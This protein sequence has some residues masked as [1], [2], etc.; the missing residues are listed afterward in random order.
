MDVTD[1]KGPSPPRLRVHAPNSQKLKLFELLDASGRLGVHRVHEV[2]AHF[3]SGLFAVVKDLSKDRLILDSRGANL[4]ERPAQRWIKTLATG[5]ALVKLLLA[6]KEIARSS[7]NDLRD[8]YYLFKVSERRSARNYLSGVIPAARIAHLRAMQQKG[9]SDGKVVASLRTLAMGDTWAV[10]LAQTAHLS[11]ALNSRTAARDG[12]ICLG[13]PLPRSATMSGLVIDDYVNISLDHEDDLSTPSYGSQLADEMSR[14]YEEAKLIPNHKKAFRDELNASFW[15]IDLDGRRGLLRGSLKRAV[16]LVG[17]LLRVAH[18]GIST[19]GLLE[20]LAGSI[21]SLMLCR[22]RLL[23]LLDSLFE[24]YKGRESS[25][26][27]VLDGR[28]KSDLLIIAVL[29]PLAVTN[30]R[31]KVSSRVT[32]TDASNWGEAS[33]IGKLEE[34]IANEMYRHTLR[35]SLWVR[36]LSPTA[37]W[38]RSHGVLSVEDEVPEPSDAYKSHPL[39]QLIAECLD[40]KLQYAKARTGNRHINIGELRAILHSEEIHSLS[41]PSV[42]EIYGS[43]SQVA[44][45]ALIKGRSS[46]PSLNNELIR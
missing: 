36:L 32:A 25:E 19:A 45:G 41:S 29:I 37:A 3:G 39:W 5:D 13:R 30:L 28:T 35:K 23:S 17:L 8:F 26:M 24:S 6:D 44:L 9:F 43:D 14:R 33:V 20:V 1:Y 4:L 22:R 21:I 40:Y 31:S 18:I 15:G 11:L 7:G 10:E 46:S 27:V 42:R 12:L 34:K 38:H 2:E 16:P